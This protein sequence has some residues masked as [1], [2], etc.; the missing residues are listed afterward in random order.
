MDAKFS[1]GD[2]LMVDYTPGSAV[3]AGDIIVVGASCRIAHLDIAANAL[4]ALA[5]GGGVYDVTNDGGTF[6]DG[7]R[8]FWDGSA[9][10]NSDSDT[11]LGVFVGDVASGDDTGR[12]QHLAQ[13]NESGST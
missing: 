9:L 2:P 7:D 6:S 12:V 8:A 11:L 3:S 13:P 1:H 5:A 10:S 4:G